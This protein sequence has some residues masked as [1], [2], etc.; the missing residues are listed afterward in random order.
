MVIP[1]SSSFD[2]CNGPGVSGVCGQ[3]RFSGVTGLAGPTGPLPIALPSPHSWNGSTVLLLVR[4][5]FTSLCDKNIGAHY[6]LGC[7]GCRNKRCN[8]MSKTYPHSH[9]VWQVMQ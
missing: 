6:F 9:R 4:H 7:I 5:Y 1:E 2:M 8:Q 3:D